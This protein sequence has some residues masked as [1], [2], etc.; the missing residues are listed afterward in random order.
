[1]GKVLLALAVAG[2][3]QSPLLALH[4]RR[5]VLER[6]QPPKVCSVTANVP[7]YRRS[8]DNPPGAGRGFPLPG[9]DHNPARVADTRLAGDSRSSQTTPE[10][11]PDGFRMKSTRE[12]A[13]R[14][15]KREKNLFRKLR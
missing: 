4:D 11:R 12:R 15:A 13:K 7:R 10:K 9:S 3:T 14:Y 6:G 1:M 5:M 8:M 2:S